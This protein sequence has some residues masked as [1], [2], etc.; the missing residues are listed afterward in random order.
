MIVY[1]Y[2]AILDG[3]PNNKYI[4]TLSDIHKK[5]VNVATG[6]VVDDAVDE[7]PSVHEYVEHDDYIEGYEPKVEETDAQNGEIEPDN[8]EVQ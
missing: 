4:R 8:I 3:K 2:P 1:Q 7:Y 6:D 5:L